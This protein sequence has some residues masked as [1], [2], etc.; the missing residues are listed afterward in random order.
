MYQY[1]SLCIIV[2]QYHC[3]TV[4]VQIAMA[5]R[6]VVIT[7][8]EAISLTFT[9]NG[10]SYGS[11]PLRV[12][13]LTYDEYRARGFNLDDSYPMRPIPA[14]AGK[15]QCCTLNPP[16]CLFWLTPSLCKI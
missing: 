2:Y 12:L 3:L 9:R 15:T 14:D 7:E 13:L 10:F 4:G 5:P 1:V 11:T 8:G 16:Y 6:E